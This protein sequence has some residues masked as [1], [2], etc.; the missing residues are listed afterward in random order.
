MQIEE[1]NDAVRMFLELDKLPPEELA[2]FDFDLCLTALNPTGPIIKSD[3]VRALVLSNGNL[4]V[5][6]AA[7]GRSRSAGK[8]YI[9]AHPDVK[10]V[11][12]TLIERKLDKVEDCQFNAAISGD[13]AAGR[14]LLQTLGKDRGFVTRTEQTG[15]DGEALMPPSYDYSK[16]STEALLE[17]KN[18][19]VENETADS[20]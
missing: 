13:T 1:M 16:M 17:L 7:V 20:A 14:F 6:A 8:R 4:S 12:E 10:E 3:V 9:D 5:L 2:L 11:Y 18:A 15:K 19:R